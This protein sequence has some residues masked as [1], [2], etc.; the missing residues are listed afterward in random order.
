M[1]A[2]TLVTRNNKEQ[3]EE[4]HA[5]TTQKYTFRKRLNT[6]YIPACLFRSE[7]FLVLAAQVLFQLS[8]LLISE[9]WL[10]RRLCIFINAENLC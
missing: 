10:G 2:E 6:E 5:L 1:I 3:I 7:E 4:N 9:G 8:V